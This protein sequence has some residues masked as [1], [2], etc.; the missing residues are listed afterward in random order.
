MRKQN[1]YLGFSLKKPEVLGKKSYL[2]D[3]EKLSQF[4]YRKDLRAIRVNQNIG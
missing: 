1:L 3:I 2:F 4:C